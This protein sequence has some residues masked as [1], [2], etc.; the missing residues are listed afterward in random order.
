MNILIIEPSKIFQLILEKTFSP[1]ATNLFIS[2]SGAEAINS[3]NDVSI[4]LICLSF[5]LSDMDSVE[6]VSGI[7]KLKFGETIPI[8]MITSKK[9]QE[10]TIKS[11]IVGV[12][13]IFRKNNLDELE[14]YLEIFAEHARQQAQI[15]G[16]ILLIDRDQKQAEEI[17][18]FF[19]NTQ[20]KFIHFTSAEEAAEIARA[21]EFDL[22]ITNVVLGGSMSGMA[23]IREI[24]E[25]N[26]TMYRVPILAISA[27]SNVS[28]KIELFRAGA[29]DYIQKPIILEELSVRMKN[30]L[31]NKK[32]FDTVELQ[33]EQLEKMAIRDQLTGIYNRHYLQEIAEKTLKEAWRYKYP[34]SIL[35]ID[36]DHFK[37]INDTYGHSTGDMVL[38]AVAK[39]LLKTF[40]G[41]DTPIRFG[42]EEFVVLLPN[43]AGEGAISRAEY[44]RKQISELRPASIQVTA[45]IGVSQTSLTVQ[46]GY[47]ELFV[48]A[49]K[50]VYAAKAKGRNCVVFFE[51]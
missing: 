10:A 11:L 47:E 3:Y 32:L 23:L 48:V 39:L 24:R 26:D 8:L 31:L 44:L 30:L 9:S 6:F 45:S 41:T 7:R 18:T 37:K 2:G 28:Q 12:T 4:D 20:L 36:L 21:A 17:R 35:V 33:K 50:A 40:R 15:E 13:E 25:I 1:Y 34:F 51:V 22:V 16:S 38:K 29:S 19:R 46:V 14:K 5:Y 43:C 49:D 27:I 42:G